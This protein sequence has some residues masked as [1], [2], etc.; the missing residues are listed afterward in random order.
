MIHNQ[1]KLF[2]WEGTEHDHL[3][4]TTDWYWGLG[5]VIVTGIIIA[6]LSKNY[7]FAIILAIGGIMLGLYANDKPHVISIEVSEHGI[8]F[9]N[10]MYTFETI[11]SFWI[12]TDVTDT[13]R[14]IIETG[15]TILPQRIVSIPA[16]V[17]ILEMRKY[18]LRF[19]EEKETKK[20][21][22]DVFSDSLG[23]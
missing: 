15:R 2:N 9:N 20:K 8:K 10:D 16:T 11:K 4:K 17:P 6:I 23:L 19:I 3:E 7:L 14:I 18:L 1:T 21:L 5:I 12:Y 22:I 13:N